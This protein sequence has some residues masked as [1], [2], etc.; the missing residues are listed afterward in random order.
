MNAKTDI[1]IETDRLILRP[2]RPED[3]KAIHAGIADFDVVRM[4]ANA[5]WPYRLEDA[6]RWLATHPA[7]DPAREQPLAIEHRQHGLIG[8]SS[9]HATSGDPF[10]EIGYW[11]ARA[12][13]GQGYASEATSAALV[14]A[15][16]G[17]GKRAVRSGHFVE[18]AASGRVLVK[19][20]MLYT[21]E[22]SPT[23]CEARGEAVPSRKM[24]WLA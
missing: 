7:K 21:G 12:H 17:W 22:V 24:I 19:A 3:A 10:P 18:N 4:L 9:F 16:E 5:P 6:E 15:H 11:V 1:R 14:W 2:P 8:M 20:G 23:F 13:W